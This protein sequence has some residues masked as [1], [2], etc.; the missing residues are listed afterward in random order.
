[1]SL[2]ILNPVDYLAECRFTSAT[3]AQALGVGGYSA[4][5]FGAFIEASIFS[6]HF[7]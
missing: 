3:V 2:A 1:M 4:A 6:P 5:R 7:N